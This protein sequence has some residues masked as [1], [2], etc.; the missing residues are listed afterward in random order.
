M[1]EER[2]ADDPG[3][4]VRVSLD[5]DMWSALVG[6]NIQEGMVGF[7]HTIP[8]ALMALARDIEEHGEI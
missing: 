2:L 1:V 7:G 3:F 6:E 5:G 8:E 4:L